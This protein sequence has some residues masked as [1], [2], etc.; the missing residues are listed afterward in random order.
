MAQPI[1]FTITEA[2][3]QAALN[4]ATDAATLKINLTEVGL[5]AGKYAV[6]GNETALASEL[7]RS[8]IVSGDVETASN[9]LRFSSSITTS[10]ITDVY[11]LGLFTDD[12]VLFAVASSTTAPLFTLHPDITFVAFFGLSLAEVSRDSVTVTTDPNGAISL[13]LMQNHLAAP[14]PHP[15]YASGVQLNN[16]LNDPDA[17]DQYLKTSDF[18]S[19][20]LEHEDPH[21]QYAMR[22]EYEEHASQ[23]EVINKNNALWQQKHVLT[24]DDNGDMHDP[25]PQY[26]P[27]SFFS[28]RISELLDMI[29]RLGGG[30]DSQDE[31]LSRLKLSLSTSTNPKAIVADKQGFEFLGYSDLDAMGAKT[32]YSQNGPPSTITYTFAFDLPAEYDPELHTVYAIAAD[33]RLGILDEDTRKVNFT[34]S[35]KESSRFVK[36]GD[37]EYTE[38]SSRISESLTVEIYGA[39]DSSGTE[40]AVIDI[41]YSDIAKSQNDFT[42]DGTVTVN[43]KTGFEFTYPTVFNL[44]TPTSNNA[45]T[46]NRNI[47]INLPAEYDP[48]KHTVSATSNNGTH[49][50]DELDKSVTFSVEVSSVMDGEGIVT[51]SMTANFKV[52]VSVA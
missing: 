19:E 52:S 48:I 13:V 23:Q 17:H 9:T 41:T 8:S 42:D 43:E 46:Y 38:W 33:G 31:L 35:T 7:Q 5:G 10:S 44:T 34:I 3:K 26:V 21:E 12:D 11:E 47:I 36:S 32:R 25:H 27:Y 24:T 50:I 22:A 15:Q 28:Q 37:D 1:L 51:D 18:V 40:L 45:N 39:L 29:R 6:T 20:H 16:H 14:N 4:A 2:G 49:V 30:Q